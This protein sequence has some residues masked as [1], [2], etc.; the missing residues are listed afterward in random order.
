M[1]EAIAI[2]PLAVYTA[3]QLSAMLDVGEGSL[4]EARRRGALRSTR[5]GRRVLFLG[6]W[7]LDW[8]RA[9]PAEQSESAG[10]LER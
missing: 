10:A 5:K 7:V 6:E 1:P 4:A 9:E 8:L 3:K 2:N